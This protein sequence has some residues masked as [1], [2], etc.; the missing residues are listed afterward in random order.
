[1]G[2]SGFSPV[3][4]LDLCEGDRVKV[5]ARGSPYLGHRGVI[6][7]SAD[8]TIF[9]PSLISAYVEFY[10]A[11]VFIQQPWD[12]SR[13]RPVRCNG[14]EV[15]CWLGDEESGGKTIETS[16]YWRRYRQ[17]QEDIHLV[18]PE[19]PLEADNLIV[20]F[21]Y[22]ILAA[23]RGKPMLRPDVREGAEGD[24][25]VRRQLSD[26]GIGSRVL[27]VAPCSVYVGLYGVV[28]AGRSGTG[29]TKGK[30]SAYVKF[31]YAGL[32]V[33][34]GRRASRT[35]TVRC[36]SLEC[37]GG[38]ELNEGDAFLPPGASLFEERLARLGAEL[39]RDVQYCW[40]APDDLIVIFAYDIISDSTRAG[41]SKRCRRRTA[42]S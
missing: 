36:T 31:E 25:G 19:G 22:E 40:L 1:M 5:T 12:A 3:G 7:K 24:A 35:R 21:S 20:R 37:V 14:L 32:F 27:V 38:A 6:V 41:A 18:S 8:G 28:V 30:I 13:V 9:T 42:V 17:L 4:Y 26:L 39:D 29:F 23:H 33:P 10:Y 15:E 11:G 2:R 34:L 16:L